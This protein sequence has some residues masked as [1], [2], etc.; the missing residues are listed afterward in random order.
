MTVDPGLIDF[1]ESFLTP[2]RK[3]LFEK[4]VNSRTNHFTVATEDV[5]QLHNTSAVMRSCDVFGIQ[6]IH[7]IEERNL[8]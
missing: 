1:L 4:V 5:Y 8:K 2:K 3:S 7:V 6:N